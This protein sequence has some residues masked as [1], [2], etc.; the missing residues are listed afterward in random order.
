[1]NIA[2]G[3]S[4]FYGLSVFTY[5]LLPGYMTGYLFGQKEYS[6]IL[7]INQMIFALGFAVG[8]L[9]FTQIRNAIGTIASLVVIMSFIGICYFSFLSATTIR[10]KQLKK[11]A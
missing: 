1:M 3:F 4:V 9:I 10:N 2:F 8:T 7:G 5:M 11:E 6:K